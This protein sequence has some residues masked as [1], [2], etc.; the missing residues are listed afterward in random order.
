MRFKNL[1]IISS[2]VFPLDPV[3]PDSLNIAIQRTKAR[4]LSNYGFYAKPEYNIQKKFNFCISQG[5]SS[6]CMQ[7]TNLQFHNLCKENVLPSG[8]RQLLGLNLKFCISSNQIKNNI[9]KTVLQ[10]ARSIR[11]RYYLKELNIDNSADYEKQIYL[12]D[13]GWHPPPAPLHIE[14]KLTMF[15]KTLKE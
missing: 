7:P 12:K 1:L 5:Q 3:D 14:D 8:T 15:E 9:N 13:K 6:S 4:C 2:Y 10:M 11:T